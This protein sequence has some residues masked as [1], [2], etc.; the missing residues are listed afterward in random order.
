MYSSNASL[1]FDPINESN[2]INGLIQQDY[3]KY[4]HYLVNDTRALYTVAA[5]NMQLK[6]LRSKV[7]YFKEQSGMID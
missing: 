7:Q 2:M 5:R 3:D 1:S 6:Y 4:G